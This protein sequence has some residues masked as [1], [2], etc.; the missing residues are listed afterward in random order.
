MA[1]NAIV[2]T[3][4]ETLDA[5]LEELVKRCVL[6]ESQFYIAYRHQSEAA[7]QRKFDLKEQKHARS[8]HR[9]YRQDSD[10]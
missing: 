4:A 3:V 7:K 2:R 5:A 1:Q 9:I 6:T 8:G 10:R